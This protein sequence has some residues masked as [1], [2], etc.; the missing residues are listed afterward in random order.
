MTVPEPSTAVCEDAVCRCAEPIPERL[1]FAFQPIIDFKTRTIFAQEALVRGAEGQ[2]AGS[3]L[4]KVTADNMHAFDRHCRIQAIKS[5][6]AALSDRPEFLSLNTMPN[7]VY[8]PATCLRTTLAAAAANSFPTHRIMF[9]MTEHEAVTDPDH[10]AMIVRSYKDMGFLTALDDFGS[11]GAGLTLLAAVMPDIIKLDMGLVRNVHISPVK[12]TILSAMVEICDRF[13]IKIIAEGIEVK[14]EA[15][16][17]FD[18]G[19]HLF[20]G[21]YFSKPQ[22]DEA[23]AISDINWS[24]AR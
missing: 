3:V 19:I 5:A 13:D 15:R 14:A 16:A 1:R 18:L 21:Y 17:L 20:Q 23:P 6:S 7:A 4:S 2:S 10:F 12:R 11:G 9:E 8:D 22:L 24:I